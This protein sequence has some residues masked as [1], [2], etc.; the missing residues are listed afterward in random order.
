MTSLQFGSSQTIEK[1]VTSNFL[2]QWTFYGTSVDLQGRYAFVS[3]P[4]Q[5]E[6]D[7]PDIIYIYKR[8]GN[9]WEIVQELKAAL[10]L[11]VFM[12]AR[13]EVNKEWLV[14]SEKHLKR[15]Y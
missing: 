14:F 2:D 3:S 11:E 4:R 15:C 7:G 10:N 12:G 9:T 6:T 13:M 8:I 5:E 1:F